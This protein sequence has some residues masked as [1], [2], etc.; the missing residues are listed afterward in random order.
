MDVSDCPPTGTPPAMDV[1]DGP[2][3]GTP[4]AM[5]V[6]DGP[7][8]QEHRYRNPVTLKTAPGPAHTDLNPLLLYN[9]HLP[10]SD[11]EWKRSL[12][13]GYRTKRKKRKKDPRETEIPL[14]NKGKYCY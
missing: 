7:P 8:N 1:S 4:P 13:L 11:R 6:S 10:W 9:R 2:P 5:D 3:T 14:I 12:K